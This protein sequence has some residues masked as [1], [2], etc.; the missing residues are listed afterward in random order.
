M[1]VR[2]R[3]QRRGS[4]NRPFFRIVVADSKNKRNGAFIETIGFFD[5]VA[6]PSKLEIKE[7]RAIDWLKKGAIPS[8]SV[9]TLL[10]KKNLN[11]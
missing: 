6:E 7:D 3:L 11:V 4:K 5:P 2:I 10:N 9:K 8:D 1:A